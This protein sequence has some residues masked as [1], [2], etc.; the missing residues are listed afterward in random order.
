MPCLGGLVA[1]SVAPFRLGLWTES[2]ASA[3]S[4]DVAEWQTRLVEGQVGIIP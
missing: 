3:R 1:Y 2:A 4:G